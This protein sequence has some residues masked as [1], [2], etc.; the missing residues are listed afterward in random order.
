MKGDS[1][2]HAVLIQFNYQH[3]LSVMCSRPPEVVLSPIQEENRGQRG[4]RITS[5]RLI[6]TISLNLKMTESHT[7][8]FYL[9]AFVNE[10]QC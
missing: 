1:V 4:G 5:G 2:G 10:I 6:T 9:V 8:N 3:V 7:R